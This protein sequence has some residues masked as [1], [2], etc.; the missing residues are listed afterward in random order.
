M[1]LFVNGNLDI[2]IEDFLIYDYVD[3]HQYD[4]IAIELV[5]PS[6]KIFHKFRI[7]SL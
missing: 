5:Y 3:F 2:V 6:K 7:Y 1:F 4:L